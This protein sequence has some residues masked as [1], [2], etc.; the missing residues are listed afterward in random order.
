[1][2][3][4]LKAGAKVQCFFESAKFIRMIFSLGALFGSIRGIMARIPGSRRA[5]RGGRQQ[6]FGD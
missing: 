2:C 5:G 3:I 1:M 4:L 6:W